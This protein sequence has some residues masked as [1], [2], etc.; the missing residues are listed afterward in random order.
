[1]DIE[2][3]DI[4]KELLKTV[5]ALVSFPNS[6]MCKHHAACEILQAMEDIGISLNSH[7]VKAI[8]DAND[9]DALFLL[10]NH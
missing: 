9:E 10:E 4:E 6:L 3:T 5:K 7:L 2:K 1:M 8:V